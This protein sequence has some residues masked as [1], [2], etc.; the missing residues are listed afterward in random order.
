MKKCPNGHRLPNGL[1]ECPVCARDNE[2]KTMYTGSIVD[3]LSERQPARMS[4]PAPFSENN[5]GLS[6]TVIIGTTSP[7]AKANLAGWLVLLDTEGAPV[8]SH[9]LFNRRMTIGRASTNDIVLSDE[10]VSGFHCSIE[11]RNDKFIINDNGSSNKTIVDGNPVTSCVLEEHAVVQLGR[12][13]FKIKYA[14]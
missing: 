10:T 14:C 9:Q 6:K 7:S 5:S 2:L 4:S 13:H 11:V 12:S 8:S 1:S 3:V